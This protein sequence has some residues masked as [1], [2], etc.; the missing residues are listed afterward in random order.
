M[1]EFPAVAPSPAR[2]HPRAFE[3]TGHRPC[4]HRAP[5]RGGK[6]STEHFRTCSYCGCIH[7]SDMIELLDNGSRFS[8]TNKR[9]KFLLFTPN[10]IAGQLVRMG[11]VP[12]AVFAKEHWP[13]VLM[14]HLLCDADAAL[15][16]VPT[17]G[18]R[19]SG[20]FERPALESAPAEIVWPFYSEHTTERQWPEI[21]AAAKNGAR[22]EIQSA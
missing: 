17:I 9:G 22:H 20:H 6:W 12:G 16:F 21:W 10:P 8:L 11:S 1:A 4:W 2:V 14:H 19:L 13:Q 15:S 7:P 3:F 5:Y 18:E